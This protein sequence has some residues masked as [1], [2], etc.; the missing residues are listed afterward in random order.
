MSDEYRNEAKRLEEAF[1]DAYE[2]YRNHISSTSYPANEDE[3]AEHDR[4]R[5]RVSQASAEWG[6]YCSDNKHMR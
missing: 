3:W 6:R 5:D 1:A 2:A 4:H